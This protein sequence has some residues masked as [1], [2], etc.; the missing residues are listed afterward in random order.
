MVSFVL[1]D[2]REEWREARRARSRCGSM[3][4]RHQVI[5]LVSRGRGV[6]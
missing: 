2:G 6:D 5:F 4:R 3:W 1:A